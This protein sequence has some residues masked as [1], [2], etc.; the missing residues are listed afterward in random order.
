MSAPEFRNSKASFLVD[1]GSDVNLIKLSA[2]RQELILDPKRSIPIT[3]ITNHPVIT[4]GTINLSILNTLVEFHVVENSIPISPDGILGRPYLRQEQAQI[5]FRHN[6]LVTA[7]NPITPIPFI[8]RESQEARKSLKTEIK[9]FSRILKIKARTRQPIAISVTNPEVAE[10]YLPKLD[11]PEGLYL[12]EAA[13]STHNGVCH[14]IAI[15]TTEDDIDIEIAPQ[16][17]IPFDFCTFPG[18][19]TS[20]SELEY[21]TLDIEKNLNSYAERAER[22]KRSLRLSHLNDEERNYVLRWAD[23]YADIFHLNGERL[24]STHLI[25]HRISTLD[26]EVIAKKQYRSH[27]THNSNEETHSDKEPTHL[28]I[29]CKIRKQS[30]TFYTPI[31]LL[32]RSKD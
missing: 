6:A 11:T 23:D 27:R 3:G 30:K 32:Q 5:S 12:G 15:N 9:P 26:N 31:H 13:V 1:P 28:W 22:V 10:G 4:I 14:A 29:R 24:S 20:D 7:S 17:V 25:Q 18:E 19:E 2:L 8:D 21:S 16:E